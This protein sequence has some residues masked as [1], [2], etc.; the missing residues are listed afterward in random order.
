M[1]FPPFNRTIF[2]IIS[3]IILIVVVILFSTEKAA[4]EIIQT[5]YSAFYP[6]FKPELRILIPRIPYPNNKTTSEM[7]VTCHLGIGEANAID[8]IIVFKKHSDVFHDPWEYGC[9]ICHKGAAKSLVT[10]QPL[11][12]GEDMP[13]TGDQAWISCL[14]CHSSMKDSLFVSKYPKV[15]IVKDRLVKCME[16]NGCKG[17][18]TAGNSGAK[19]GPSLNGLGLALISDPFSIFPTPFDKIY[20][21]LINPLEQNNLTIMPKAQGDSTDITLLTTFLSYQGRVKPNG[22]GFTNLDP[23]PQ[24]RPVKYVYN[25]YCSACHGIEG[26]GKPPGE[27]PHGV[28]S[29]NAFLYSLY[30]D[31]VFLYNTIAG[32]REGTYMQSFFPKIL[33]TSEIKNVV[34]L[35]KNNFHRTYSPLSLTT[36]K[37]TIDSSC[38]H[39]HTP[40]DQDYKPLSA[41]DWVTDF[42]KHNWNFSYKDLI[43]SEKISKVKPVKNQGIGNPLYD[44]LCIACHFDPGIQLIDQLGAPN[45]GTLIADS[46]FSDGN[47]ILNVLLGRQNDYDNRW[48]H[49]GITNHEY[50]IQDI[51]SVIIY[52]QKRKH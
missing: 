24:T 26:E 22:I 38:T 48:N 12:Y 45:L 31:T 23:D 46:T 1:T 3:T 39:C 15:P 4:W 10:H 5:R 43:T 42:Q 32:G 36:Y 37:K 6:E 16:I 50:S 7:C 25:T 9:V 47:F 11:D 18:H 30:I 28:V 52:L 2:I 13:I 21:R 35:I 51:L 33:S 17:C 34:N 14:F 19:I 27:F 29:L 49:Q 20:N 41:K 44:S 40:N 8:S